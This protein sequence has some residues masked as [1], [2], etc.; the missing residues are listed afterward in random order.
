MPQNA[1]ALKPL[2]KLKF[3]LNAFL[4]SDFETDQTGHLKQFFRE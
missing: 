4:L 1:Q 3:G 2:N